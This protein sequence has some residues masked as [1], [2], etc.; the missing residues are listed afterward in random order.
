MSRKILI[1]DDDPHLRVTFEFHLVRSGYEVEAAE[2]AEQALMRLSEVDPDVVITDL[3]M[4]G[5]SGLELLQRIK[6]ARPEIDVVVITGYE[7]MQTT[8]EAVRDGAYDYLVKPLDV[9]QLDVV[10]HRCFR[11]RAARGRAA[12]LKVEGSEAEAQQLV[13]G[14]SRQMIEIYKMIGMLS[15]TRAPVLIRG[16]T[17]TGKELVARAIHDNSMQAAE[18]FIAVNC[19]ALTESLLES[20]LF[21]HTKGSFT[22]AMADRRGRFALAGAGTIF[23]DEIGDTTPAFQSKLLRVL[24]ER[25][26][27]PVGGE[28]PQR[29]E[30]RVVAATH[31]NMEEMIRSGDFREDLYFR[32]RVVEITVPP[33]RERREDIPIL[34]RHLLAK[35]A[36]EI[37]KDVH[38][39]PDE[40]MRVLKAHDWPGNVR[41]LE[42]AI[43]RAAVLAHG[44]A[45][46]LDHLSLDREGHNGHAASPAG[47][48]EPGDLSLDAIEKA[49]VQRV[50]NR[51]GGN[52]RQTASL[53]GVSRPRL[54]RIIEK[55]SLEVPG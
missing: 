50:L 37:H 42:N 23:L 51:T 39:V 48:A 31:R 21:G 12:R 4:G 46:S 17:G 18:P 53:L 1:V 32:L 8:V 9:D 36:R 19:T 2:S 33:L 20:E 6:A 54:D 35:A 44:P 38:V 15:A 16:E 14:H 45:L 52:K 5:M 43:M 10:L 55:H 11:D 13:V 47:S 29:T 26:F 49:H 40:V 25:E 3:Q 28:K 22:G 30:A 24:Q 7:S 27:Y 41:E 34:V